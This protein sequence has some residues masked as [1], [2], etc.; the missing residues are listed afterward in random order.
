[1]AR[2]GDVCEIVA[3]Q[4]PKSKYYNEEKH[5]TPF[6]QGK[7]LFGDKFL[8]DPNVWTS[9]ETK[10]AREGSVLMSVRAPVG[11]V[12]ITNRDICIGRGLAALRNKD[13]LVRDYLFYFLV[14][15]GTS[16]TGSTG[17]VFNSINK[18]QIGDI[19][20][21][22]PPLPVQ[23]QIVQRLDAAF[24]QIDRAI[25][26]TQKKKTEATRLKTSIL[27]AA[28]D[29]DY[30]GP[31]MSWEMVR[32]GDIFQFQ[33]G[34]SFK[35][36]ERSEKGLPIIRIQNLN[37]SKAPFNYFDGQ[38]S[39]NIFVNTGELLFSWSGNVGTSF[40][41]H[42]WKKGES[43]LNQHIYK[44]IALQEGIDPSYSYYALLSIT[45]KIENEVSGAVGLAHITKK[46]L[47]NFKIP[48]PPLPVQKQIV[49]RLDA[50][51]EQIDLIDASMSKVEENYEALKTSLLNEA[52]SGERIEDAA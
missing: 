39:E 8:K 27:S 18:A 52:V 26:A 10:I 47:S 16:L 3:G 42:I 11:T 17:A 46:K 45:A 15:I 34:R 2:L 37:N 35:R 49:Q 48:L 21:P 14:S 36:T 13:E 25:S 24:K 40:G 9:K 12:N 43:L 5:G 4:S 44:V 30:Q 29:P 32:L 19:Q 41:P 22:L 1:M 20:I 23:K 38:Y 28:L 6:Y 31:V 51:F 50:A 33:N 7:K